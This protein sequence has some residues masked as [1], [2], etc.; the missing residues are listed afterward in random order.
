[1]LSTP[2]DLCK[3]VSTKG[4]GGNGGCPPSL[5]F[6]RRRA[7]MVGEIQDLTGRTNLTFL[8]PLSI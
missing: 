5:K 4:N 8:L 3:E 6:A 2:A 1:M 7:A